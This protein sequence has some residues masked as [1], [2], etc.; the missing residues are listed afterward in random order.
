MNRG[1]PVDTTTR[2]R[3]GGMTVLLTLVM[4]WSMLPLFTVAALAPR[5]RPDLGAGPAELGIAVGAGFAVAAALSPLAG[6]LTDRWGPRR[7]TVGLLVLA[8]AGL[9]LLSVSQELVTLCLA[10][11][12]S[13]LP[14]AFANPV[15]NKAVLRSVPAERRGGVTGWKQS[16]VQ[17]GALVAGVPLSLVAAWSGWREAVA[18]AAAVALLLAVWALLALAPDA[19]VGGVRGAD[20]EPPPRGLV[21]R[22]AVF[23]LF[24]G[25]GVSSMNAHVG[26]FAADEL[27]LAPVA[28][29]LVVAVLG[30]AGVLGRVLW[31]ARA[32]RRGAFGLLAPLAGG[33]VLGPALLAAASWV[34]ELVYPA[35]VA[36]GGLAVAANAVSMIAVMSAVPGPRAGRATALVSAGFFAGFAVGPGVLGALAETAG[37]TYAWGWPA[38]A[39]LAAG[40]TA[41]PWLRGE[42]RA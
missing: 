24:L 16:G 10:L 42:E 18:L 35:A 23:S 5:L 15:T 38:L 2:E 3:V 21:A 12:L 37:Y 36:V 17:L 20:A 22:L 39:L 26:L 29:G 25:A 11:A 1:R 30:V 6:R 41:T 13:G 40:A 14:Q 4:A 19:P 8:A 9:G 34:P 7:C 27:G 32:G 33:A 28:A 31:A